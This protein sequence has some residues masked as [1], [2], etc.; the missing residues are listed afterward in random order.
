NRI[1]SWWDK[2]L[3]G[4]KT[5]IDLPAEGD[6]FLYGPK[7]KEEKI[8]EIWRIGD[9]YNVSIGQGNLAVTPIRLLT[10][11]SFLANDGQS[12]RPYIAQSVVDERGNL[13]LLN[14]PQEEMS[15]PE[16]QPSIYEI[17]KGLRDAVSKSYGTANSLSGLPIVV[18]G[19]TGSAQ[20]S[21]NT[22]TNAFFVGYAPVD[23]P[24]I[25]L[26]ILIEDSR[27]GSLNTLPIARDVF[28]WY[29]YNRM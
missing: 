22:K 10:A 17:K 26:L 16:W 13:V 1:K 28:E 8:G 27:E 4:K 19:K 14:E 11:I 12:F 7:E 6:G 21:N 29:Y 23:D 20:I 25:A 9:T 24:E 15:Y 5:G 3:L 18:A 2:L